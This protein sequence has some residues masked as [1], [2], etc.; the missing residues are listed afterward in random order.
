MKHFTAFLS[1]GS[2]DIIV[3]SHFFKYL[4]VFLLQAEIL[5]VSIASLGG[6]VTKVLCS[7]VNFI[8]SNLIDVQLLCKFFHNKAKNVAP[9]QCLQL[10]FV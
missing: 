5:Q 10:L 2:A 8:S 4:K 1:F 7:H 6:E 3:L 9:L